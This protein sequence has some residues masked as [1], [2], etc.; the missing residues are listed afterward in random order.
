[1]KKMMNFGLKDF[2]T[3]T[4]KTVPSDTLLIIMSNM[5]GPSVIQLC[6]T[7]K[8]IRDI[9]NKYKNKIYGLLLD[10]D[11]TNLKTD[12]KDYKIQYVEYLSK[13]VQPY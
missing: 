1:M 12:T 8:E 2:I 7:S 4:S 5:S 10:R 11:F 13:V 9:C 6:S 3:S